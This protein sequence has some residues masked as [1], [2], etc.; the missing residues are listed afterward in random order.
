VQRIQKRSVL[1]WFGRGRKRARRFSLFQ[2]FELLTE[3]L[4]RRKNAS[5]NREPAAATFASSSMSKK[6]ISAARLSNVK[7]RQGFTLV[8]LLVVIAIIGI[9]SSILLPALAKAKARAQGVYCINNTR[10]L[11]FGWMMY[12]DDSNGKLAYN[13]GKTNATWMNVNWVNN[14]ENWELDSDN[15][16]SAKVVAS[17]LGPYVSG[18][19]AV[20]RCPSDYVISSLQQQAGW[21]SRVR[22]YSMN[23][24][25]GDAGSFL[26]GG[27][28]VNNPDYVQF[29][30]I[31]SI[32]RP[33]DIFVFL[34]EHP[35]SIDDGYFINSV[36]LPKTTASK[37]SAAAAKPVAQWHDL[38]ASYHDGAASFA[39]A[40]GHSEPHR[41]R[42]TLTKPAAKPGAA[43]LPIFIEPTDLQD[44][45]WIISMMSVERRSDSYHY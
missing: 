41:W 43:S 3:T 23:A 42:R 38:P 8:E 21:N 22:S 33:S 32:P 2:G 11:A 45:I 12:S 40:D 36:T 9:L 29:L 19:A 28:N 5:R 25:V 26:Q 34:D 44:F 30:N 15:T 39:F 16:N 13:L 14:I 18:P 6:L 1:S 17:G 27:V 7:S 4:Q 20:Y 35:D 24:M 37:S 31:S 10:Q